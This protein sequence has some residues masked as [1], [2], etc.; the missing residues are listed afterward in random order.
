MKYSLQFNFIDNE[1]Q[2][3]D[4]SSN[5]IFEKK[6]F[7]SEN[8]INNNKLNNDKLDYNKLD[9]KIN[10]DIKYLSSILTQN[11]LDSLYQIIETFMY[12]INNIGNEETSSQIFKTL[13]PIQFNTKILNDS[14]ILKKNYFNFIFFDIIK[15]PILKNEKYISNENYGI[16]SG[17][18]I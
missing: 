7:K 15:K 11:S 17:I 5:D 13:I 12:K 14:K 8:K 2:L 4:K 9:Y 18:F 6:L 10:N 16:I 1:I 3:N